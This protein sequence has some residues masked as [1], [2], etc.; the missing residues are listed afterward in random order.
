MDDHLW[1]EPGRHGSGEHWEVQVVGP[2]GD[3][4]VRECWSEFANKAAAKRFAKA[5][6]KQ[7]PEWWIQIIAVMD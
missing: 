7:H 5:L 3:P 2:P 6:H 4:L 1:I